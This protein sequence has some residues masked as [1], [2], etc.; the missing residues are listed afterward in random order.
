[1][2]REAEDLSRSSGLALPY[3]LAMYLNDN[4]HV[5]PRFFATQGALEAFATTLTMLKPRVKAQALRIAGRLIIKIAS[6]VADSGF[7]SGPLSWSRKGD[8]SLDLDVER[9]IEAYMN[10]PSAGLPGNL[11]FP[12]R[13]RERRVVILMLDHSYS[14]K[15]IKMLLAAICAASVAVHCRQDYGVIVFSKQGQVLKP[16]NSRQHPEVV[17]EKLFNL[18]LD[19]DTNLR[20]ALELGLKELRGCEKK[21]GLLLTDGNWNTGGDPR[22]L[23]AL[24]DKLNIICFPPANPEKI[25]EL[26]LAGK[27]TF[28]FVAKESEIPGAI[29]RCLG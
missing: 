9:T 21:T 4:P 25:K 12:E 28:K 20:S 15:G 13:R 17:L 8:F 27:G 18:N 6:Q 7:Q 3:R 16:L 23:A 5:L 26:A 22:E 14:M 19:G 11:V 1:M 2:A 29:T 10:D 24:F